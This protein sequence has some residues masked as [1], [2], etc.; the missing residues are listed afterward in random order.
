MFLLEQLQSEA[1]DWLSG[2]PLV[3]SSVLNNDS[4]KRSAASL[5][6]PLTPTRSSYSDRPIRVDILLPV[7]SVSWPSTGTTSRPR[8]VFTRLTEVISEGP[9]EDLN[10]C[11]KLRTRTRN[12]SN[13]RRD[14]GGKIQM[15]RWQMTPLVQKHFYFQIWR[16]SDLT[17]WLVDLTSC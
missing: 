15:L 10:I 14:L 4:C 7:V 5:V 12:I 1:A 6:S 3:F 2:D 17:S 9:L 13:N 8:V 16:L 11:P